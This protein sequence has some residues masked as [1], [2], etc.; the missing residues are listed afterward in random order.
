VVILIIGILISGASVGV[1]LY[2]DYRLATAKSITVNSRVSRI[3][4]LEMWV[5][6]TLDGAFSKVASSNPVSYELIKKPYN[7]QPVGKWN[8]V[9]LTQNINSEI[10]PSQATSGRQPFYI[11]SAINGLPALYFDGKT[12]G[13]GDFMS[14]TAKFINDFSNFT[15]FIVEKRTGLGVLST[16]PPYETVYQYILSTNDNGNFA[17]GP[18]LN[19]SIRIYPGSWYFIG[20]YLNKTYLHSFL[21]DENLGKKIYLNGIQKLSSSDKTK[22]TVPANNFMLKIAYFDRSWTQNYYTGFIGEI[23]IFSKVLNDAERS[24]VEKYLIKKWQIF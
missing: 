14:F 9:K 17:V 11:E 10:D 15:I 6:T 8:N 19:G 1:D 23:I 5:E 7:N 24:D 21:I 2:Q 13:T 22:A 18:I 20:N 16:N 3:D 4:N 12:D